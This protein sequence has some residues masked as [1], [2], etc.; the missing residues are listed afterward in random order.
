M[1][2]GHQLHIHGPSGLKCHP[3]ERANAIADCLDNQ[4][5]HHDLCDKNNERQVEA[6]VQTLL[7]AVDNKPPE[8][9]RPCDL[10]KLITSLKLR[11][12]CRIDGI[13]NECLGHLLRRSLVHLTHLL[14]HFIRLSDFPKSWKEA[15]NT[16]LPKHGKDPKFPQNLSLI[17]LMFTMG[18]LFRKVILKILQKLIDEGGLLNASQIVFRARHSTTLQCMRL[19]D[20]VTLNFNSK[21]STAAVFLDIEKTFDTTWYNGLLYKLSK[22]EFST[23]LIKLIGYFLSQIKYR[24]S[25]EGEMSTPRA[26]QAGVPQD[27]VLSPTLFNMCINEGPQSHGVHLDL[28]ADDTRLYATDR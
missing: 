1:D 3:F 16:T 7:E 21:I 11:Q 17:S 2:Q 12:S 4:F 20:Y 23:N 8:R 5:T 27:S 22:L 26:M 25:V 28:F 15:K 18:K 14:N 13:L 24:V 6:S 9:M 10:Q 19:T